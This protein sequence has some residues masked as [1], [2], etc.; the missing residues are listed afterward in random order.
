MLAGTL[1]TYFT[2][3]NIA[4]LPAYAGLHLLG[5]V[6]LGTSL[7]LAPLALAGVWAGVLLHRRLSAE[8]FY[9]LCYAL[10]FVSGLKLL[11]DALRPLLTSG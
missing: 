5:R 4:K 3:L 1:V 8:W 2:V 6:S 7:L 9:R 11:F 10:V